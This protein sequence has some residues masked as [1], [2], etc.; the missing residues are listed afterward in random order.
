MPSKLENVA[1]DAIYGSFQPINIFSLPLIKSLLSRYHF[2][3]ADD[4][5][6]LSVNL[7]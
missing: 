3:I 2:A 5:S 6:P 4:D 1:R 7:F